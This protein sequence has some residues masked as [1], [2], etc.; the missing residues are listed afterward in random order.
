MEDIRNLICNCP[1]TTTNSV[2]SS[3]NIPTISSTIYILFAELLTSYWY[4]EGILNLIY[5]CPSTTARSVCSTPYIPIHI[6]IHI[7]CR[8]T[9]IVLTSHRLWFTVNYNWSI[10]NIFLFHISTLTI[11]LC[12]LKRLYHRSKIIG[13]VLNKASHD[14]DLWNSIIKHIPIFL[15]NKLISLSSEAISFSH[16]NMHM[17]NINNFMKLYLLLLNCVMVNNSY[18]FVINLNSSVLW[19]SS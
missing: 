12:L 1:T 2:F 14:H 10:T 6:I 17:I 5:N 13:T 15:K 19:W 9:H 7:V 11:D 18:V 16:T 4:L 8:S 3:H